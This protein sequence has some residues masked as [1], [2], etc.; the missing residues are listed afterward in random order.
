MEAQLGAGGMGVVYRARDTKLNRLVAIKFLSETV[1]DAAA[2]GRFQSEAQ[3]A[4]SL[5]HP[6]ILTVHDVGELD[7]RQYLVTEFVDG[8]TLREWAGVERTWPQ[9]VELLVGVADGLA[10]A[11]VA[12]IV[13]RDIKPENILVAKNGYAKLADFGLAKLF[14]SS[15]DDT[16]TRTRAAGRTRPGTIIGTVAYMSPEQASGKTVDA[17]SDIFAFGVVL[18]ELLAR[19]H[20]FTGATPLEVLQRVQHQPAAPLGEAIAAA[21]RAVVDKALEKD[22]AARYQSMR[23]LVVDLRRLVRH[24]TETSA[25]TTKVSRAWL[26]IAAA[27]VLVTA[28]GAAFWRTRPNDAGTAQIRSIAVLPFQNL[29]RDPDQEFFAD[30][31]TET[32]ISSLA[33]IHAL[34]VTSRT[35]MMR[36]KGTTMTLPEIARELGVDAIVEGSVQRAG[37]RVRVTAQ[38][39]RASTD[40]H[41]W[42]NDYDRDTADFLQMQAEVARA[43]AREIEVQ[44]TPEES[45][46]LANTR[47][48]RPE[49]QEAYLLGRHFRHKDNEAGLKQAVAYFGREIELQPD[50]AAAY[51]SL[52]PSPSR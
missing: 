29:S 36:Y 10:A 18:Y 17:R 40:T 33:Q 2:R 22:P 26:G 49:A 39:I 14:E 8:G 11:H 28:G 34:D 46:Q 30:G 21:L 6:H 15:G 47:R 50:Y 42:A 24:T 35:S 44:I 7:G 38:L 12:G 25:P 4:S 19:R 27:L 45:R 16:A 20:P 52:M 23:E 51:A 1:A 32:L 5:N 3:T 48:I 43:I 13:H 9:I 41:L 37:G 31:T